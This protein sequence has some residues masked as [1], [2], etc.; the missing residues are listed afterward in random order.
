M[1]HL[2]PEAPEAN[3]HIL[4]ERI[5]MFWRIMLICFAASTAS[6]CTGIFHSYEYNRLQ[7]CAAESEESADLASKSNAEIRSDIEKLDKNNQ[8]MKGVLANM[9]PEKH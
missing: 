4:K 9:L 7:S 8:Q 3:F 1:Q 5:A 2:D 6:A